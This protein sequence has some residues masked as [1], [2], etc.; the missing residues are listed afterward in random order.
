MMQ[1]Y[2]DNKSL[3]RTIHGVLLTSQRTK[4]RVEIL[5]FAISIHKMNTTVA[6]YLYFIFTINC[7]QQ[8]SNHAF[9]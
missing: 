9:L 3:K 2:F 6:C 4:M 1:I 5:D 7:N 8:I